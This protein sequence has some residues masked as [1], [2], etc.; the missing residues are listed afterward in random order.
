MKLTDLLTRD[1]V[2]DS[3]KATEAGDAIDELMLKL[4]ETK[5]LSEADA[6]RAREIV[7]A[8]ERS[9]S[10]GIGHGVAIPH[11]TVP[12]LDGVIGVLGRSA[13]GIDFKSLDGQ[14]VHI[15]VLVLV[16]ES[17]YRQHIRTLAI[18]SRLLNSAAL[19]EQLLHARGSA[20]MMRAIEAEECNETRQHQAL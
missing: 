3:L 13:A 14:P 7:L 11:G 6:P 4:I 12:G 17:A 19:R 9:M 1:V 5:R 8:R 15:A 10:T 16:G 18:V 20:E 2:I